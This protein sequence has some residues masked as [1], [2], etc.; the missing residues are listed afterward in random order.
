MIY[1]IVKFP[2]KVLDKA[3]AHVKHFDEKLAALV[4]DMFVSMYKAH[5]VGLAAPQIGISMHLAVIDISVGEDPTQKI[6]LCNP[7]IIETSGRQH[8]EEGCLSLPGFRAPTTRPM[9]ATVRAQDLQGK[10][11]ELTGEGL[12][13][14]AICHETDHLNGKLFISHLS[15]LRRDMIK[16]KIRR[17][18]KADEWD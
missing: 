17:M 5:G 7:E 3:G 12:L 15:V 10:S 18:I 13:A 11:F 16:R 9:K 2:A 1:P 6:V 4:D 8:E 14:R